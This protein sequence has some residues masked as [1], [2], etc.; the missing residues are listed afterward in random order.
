[1]EEDARLVVTDVYDYA[2]DRARDMGLEVTSPDSIMDV[3]CDIF[4]PCALGGVLNPQTIPQL[5]CRVVAGGANN[6]LL[7][8]ADGEELHRRGILYAPDYIVNSGGIINVE[9]EL[10]DA[11]YSPERAREK[12]ERIH[13]IMEQRHQDIPGP[14]DFHGHR[15]RHL[16]RGTVGLRPGRQA[17]ST[18][19]ARS[20]SCA[21]VSASWRSAMTTPDFDAVTDYESQAR[22]FLAQS[23]EYLANGRL[24]QAS[25]KG[26]GAAAHMVKAVAE[27]QGW[28]Y[29]RHADFSRVMNQASSTDRELTA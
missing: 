1:M 2:L 13:E 8:E 11:G 15:R 27:A 10:G 7:S 12:T 18:A 19:A 29:D 9:A 16:G 22:E 21:K 14:G 26:W 6:Q 24:H 5:R 25:E 23:R 4:A 17:P 3:D 28:T 20:Q